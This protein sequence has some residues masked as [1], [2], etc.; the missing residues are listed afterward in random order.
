MNTCMYS[1]STCIVCVH[2]HHLGVGSF[3]TCNTSLKSPVFKVDSA[4]PPE[5]PQ[6]RPL[7]TECG[8]KSTL[9]HLLTALVEL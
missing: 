5:L 6:Y 3:I 4:Q 7:V 9:R 8:F 2:V 1:G